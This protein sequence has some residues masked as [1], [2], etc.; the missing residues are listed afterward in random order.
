MPRPKGEQM[1]N[2]IPLHAPEPLETPLTDQPIDP[3]KP[4]RGVKIEPLNKDLLPDA[5][6]QFDGYAGTT[7]DI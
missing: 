2:Q 1:A 4:K 3:N 7:I 5:R 6:D